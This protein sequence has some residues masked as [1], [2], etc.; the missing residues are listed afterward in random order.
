MAA[1]IL[2]AAAVVLPAS[3]AAASDITYLQGESLS[4]PSANGM[5]YS[6]PNAVGGQALAIWSNA[7]ATG[8]VTLSAGAVDLQIT[9]MSGYCDGAPQMRLTID[10]VVHPT[11]HGVSMTSWM[12]YGYK[13]DLAPGTHSIGVA[14]INEYGTA[15]CDR[16]L[17]IDQLKFGA[18]PMWIEAEDSAS[19]PQVGEVITDPYGAY[20]G[21]SVKLTGSAAL[22][23]PATTYGGF[24]RVLLRARGT[25]CDGDPQMQLKVDGIAQN[26]APTG[27]PASTIYTVTPKLA[28]PWHAPLGRHVT[29]GAGAHTFAISL[30]NPY[31]NATT[32]CTRTLFFD[33]ILLSQS[34]TY[35]PPAAPDPMT[36]FITRSGKSLMLNGKAFKYAGMNA[37]GMSGCDGPAWTDAKL[38]DYFSRLAPNT[39]TR[40]WAFQPYGTAPLDRI[41]ARAAAHNQKVIFTLSD[42]RN[43]CGEYDGW[44]GSEGGDKTTA[45]Y[46]SGFRT[47]FKP[48]AQQ[49]VTRYKDNP[50]L[51]MWEIINE[52]GSFHNTAYTDAMIRTFL[53]EIAAAIKAIDT[54]HLISSG[55]LSNDMYGTR[56]Y[57]YVHGGPNIDVASLHE[58]EYDYNNSNT[59]IANRLPTLLNAL[60][61]LHK[62]LIVGET[63]IQAAASGCRTTLTAR[64]SPIQQKINGYLGT[65]G[66]AGVNVWSVV[67]YNPYNPVRPDDPCPLEMMFDDP[68]LPAV[69]AAQQAR[70]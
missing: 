30:V 39:V 13:I 21:K 45:W 4:V 59:I 28:S 70:N 35:V 7:T 48:W 11:V 61:P 32:G 58:Y 60:S 8:Q 40:T 41:L 12:V 68:V 9:A 25:S 10:G 43:Y 15:S 20:G 3:P 67:Q 52:P 17:E 36:G 57:A 65:T 37:Y 42:G 49:V 6:D 22:T 26:L 23:M 33:D 31:S 38:D 5:V 69:K 47:N 62:P 54:K 66:V 29:F 46:T 24:D 50:A 2:A 14:F 64:V 51:A 19:A 27:A 34:E 1:A 53:D 55:A 18:M 16:F 44:T 63:G 56:D